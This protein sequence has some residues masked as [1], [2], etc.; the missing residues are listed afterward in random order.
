VR[1]TRVSG[2]QDL[3]SLLDVVFM[4]GFTLEMCI[5]ITAHGFLWTH[6]SQV[7]LLRQ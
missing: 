6:E 5:K 3:F 4:V 2:G 1:V 7:T